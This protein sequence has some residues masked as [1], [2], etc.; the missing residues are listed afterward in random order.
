MNCI[1]SHHK[2]QQIFII[3]LAVIRIIY[4]DTVLLRI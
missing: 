4:A 2:K 3:I 1:R